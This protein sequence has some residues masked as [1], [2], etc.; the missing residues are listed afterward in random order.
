MEVQRARDSA[1]PED[2][3]AA[4]VILPSKPVQVGRIT[5]TDVDET[6]VF[7]IFA[8]LIQSDELFGLSVP[9]P[10]TL[11]GSQQSVLSP[12]DDNTSLHSTLS[13]PLLDNQVKQQTLHGSNSARRVQSANTQP[14]GKR[15]RWPGT[16]VN[17]IHPLPDEGE[18][19]IMAYL[20]K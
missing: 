16:K 4:S 14:G 10:V 15:R 1:T 2:S 9:L 5:V 20:L 3:S 12:D 7:S 11:Q 13:A 17:A 18:G 8:D 19:I 6:V